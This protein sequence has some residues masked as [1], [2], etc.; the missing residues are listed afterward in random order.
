MRLISSYEPQPTSP[1]PDLARPGPEREAERVAEPVRDDPPPA[2]VG[3]PDGGIVRR[4]LARVRVQPQDRAVQRRRLSG[5][6]PEAL[7]AQRAALRARRGQPGPGGSGRIAARVVGLPEVG[8]VVG[9]TVARAHVEHPVGPEL[10]GADGVARVLLAD[11]LEQD[12]LVTGEAQPRQAR[13]DR[14]APVVGADLVRARVAPA[15]LERAGRG[16]VVRVGD[17]EEAVPGLVP[18]RVERQPEHPA[19]P[20]VEHRRAQ[21][22]EHRRRRV[23]DAVEL[24]HDPALGGHE[25]L[26]VGREAH[27]RR[28][29]E[30]LSTP[31]CAR[32]PG[33]IRSQRPRAKR[34]ETDSPMRRR[35]W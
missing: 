18:A 22:G 14:A 12:G 21:V 34:P 11:V 24:P 29:P 16:L 35:A 6:A 8:A 33:A 13:V 15:F 30:V 7:R 28:R 4:G 19:V 2:L 3:V 10:E 26:A 31:S 9:G 25:H 27:H 17:V 23:L 32:T 1:G 5:G 20:G